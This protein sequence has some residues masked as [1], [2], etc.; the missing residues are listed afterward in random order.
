[1]LFTVAIV[2]RPNVGKSTLFNRLVGKRLALVDDQPGVTRDRREGAG[3]LGDLQFTAV[4]T[5]GLEDVDGATLEGRMRAQTERAVAEADVALFLIDA[6]A[7]I[8]PMD[9]HFA[10]VLRR[11]ETPVVLLANKCEGNASEAGRVEAYALGLG[12]P[13]PVSAKHGE[14]LNMLYDALAPFAGTGI[15]DNG[16][17]ETDDAESEVG[18]LQLAVVGRPNV[19]KSTLINRLIGDER[20]LTG[21]EAGITRDAISI[22]WEFRRRPIRLVDTAGLRR[23]ARVDDRVEGLAGA[24]ARRAIRFA[25]VAVLVLDATQPLEKQDLTIARMIAEEGRAPVIALNKWDL[26]ADRKSVLDAVADRIE[27]SLAQVRGVRVVALSALTGHG[28]GRLL[29]TVLD[30]DAVWNRRVGTGPLNRWLAEME[31]RHPPPLVQGRRIR[32]RYATQAKARPPT[33]VIFASRPKGLPESYLRYL[34]NGLRDAFDLDGV[35]V[36]VLV[37]KG[38]NPYAAD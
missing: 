36:R 29:P 24:D 20:L 2:G 28:L 32:L 10:D 37:R 16:A 7:G 14:G 27:T 30:V 33:F 6:R 21:P 19:G 12:D 13:L 9:S 18:P 3:R 4:D 31:Q 23:R 35:P 17:T 8:T 22:S 11:T 1:M 38:K 5:A 15:V 25:H 26:V 34:I